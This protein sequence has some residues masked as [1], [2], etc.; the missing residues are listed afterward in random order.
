MSAQIIDLPLSAS[1]AWEA[2]ASLMRQEDACPELRKERQHV[3]RVALAR[4]AFENA[5][6]RE[7][8]L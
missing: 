1:K 6:L 2:Y 4:K 7:C 5:F 3:E 8:G